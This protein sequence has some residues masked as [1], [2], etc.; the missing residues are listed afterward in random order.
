[1][2]SVGEGLAFGIRCVKFGHE[3]RI[4]LSP[5][6]NQTTG[7]GF[8]G[9]EK[10]KNWVASMKWADLILPTGNHDFMQRLDFFRKNGFK[11]FGPSMASANIEIDRASG[12]SLFEKAG[13]EVPPYHTFSTLKEAEEFVWKNE[14]RFVFKTMGDEDDKSL[15]YCAKS[16]ADMIARL[17][18]WQK[19][20]LNP[21]G[22][23]MLQEFIEGVEFGVDRWMGS[24]G[25]I[26]KYN[27]H[28]E[29]KKFLSGNYGQN[30][31]ESGTVQKYVDGSMLGEEVLAPLENDL[32]GLGHLGDV[33]VNCIIDSDGKSWPLEFTMRL[34]WPAFNIQVASHKGDP[35]QWMLDACNG[36][37]SLEVSPQHAVGI[38][39]AQPDYPY[40]KA[41]KKETEGVP[42]YGVTP[43]NEKYIY[44]QSV[45][46]DKM[47]DMDKEHVVEKAMWVTTGD[48]V[49]VVTA[50]GNTV[51]KACE[52]AYKTVDELNL[53]D[54]I[55]RD[56]IGEKLEEQIPQLQAHGYALEFEY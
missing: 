51:K 11:V 43:K 38:V 52:R 34:G 41:T 54:M 15:S 49:G 27:E 5:E 8:D 39:I 47:P 7:D 1:M 42:I 17:Q 12:M 37:D 4:Y 9:I 20:K 16:P 29:H 33:A 3:V 23:V 46:I 30:C 45:K 40:S 31:G 2:D 14:E 10:V 50:L 28:F 22:K 32:I 13:I 48:Y 18:R 35:A 55:C 44:P 21:K 56:D 53:S 25:F 24:G 19:L 36:I 6:N 26:G